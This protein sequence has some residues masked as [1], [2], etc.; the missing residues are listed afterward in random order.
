MIRACGRP[1]SLLGRRLEAG[2]SNNQTLSL[3]P[4]PGREESFDN[5]P[6]PH[7]KTQDGTDSS[8]CPVKVSFQVLNRL[9]YGLLINYAVLRRYQCLLQFYA[10]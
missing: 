10:F 8:I 6:S 1:K 2:V 5:P 7:N 3:S 4:H 9:V